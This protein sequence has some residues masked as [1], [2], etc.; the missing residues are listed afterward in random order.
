MTAVNFG[1]NRAFPDSDGTLGRAVGLWWARQAVDASGAV[2]F[3]SGVCLGRGSLYLAAGVGLEPF[4]SGWNSTT[5]ISRWTP[6]YQHCIS[7]SRH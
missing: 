4:V 2:W 6:C 1:Q 5:V 7:K 3:V